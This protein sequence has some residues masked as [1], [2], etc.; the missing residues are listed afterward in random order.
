MGNTKNGAGSHDFFS[1][2]WFLLNVVY[3]RMEIGAI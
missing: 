2:S 3:E 1:N